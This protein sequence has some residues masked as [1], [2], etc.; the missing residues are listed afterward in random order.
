MKQFLTRAILAS[1]LAM[2]P[3]VSDANSITFSGTNGS[4]LSASAT[5]SN[6][7]AG[8]LTITLTN[9][10]LADANVPMDVLTAVFF[11]LNA[12]A[13]LSATGSS[14]T[15]APGS[16]VVY[17]PQGQPAGGNVGGEW[18]V[19]TDVSNTY[20][21][22]FGLSS[23]GLGGVFGQ[24]NLNGLNLAGPAALGGLQYG[25]LPAGWSA[26]GDNGGLTH[27]DGLIKNSVVFLIASTG[28]L[29]GVGNVT[30]QYGTALNEGHLTG[31]GGA[32]VTL[33]ETSVPD[34]GT[35]SIL[36]G[37]SMVGV[38]YARRKFSI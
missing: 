11:N 6:D 12:G 3:A 35:T 8:F 30:F 24:P 17:D 1:T 38:A 37:L 27:T 10:S 31:D 33:F 14:A 2:L 22:N 21:A 15:L 25:I 26:L 32:D 13:S 4:N 36:L 16:S 34:G 7:I 20:N 29:T 23:S 19:Q 9:A 18:A 28:P 5:F